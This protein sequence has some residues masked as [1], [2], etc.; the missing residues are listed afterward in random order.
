MFYV[1]NVS[2]VVVITNMNRCKVLIKMP[3][4]N[5]RLSYDDYF[6]TILK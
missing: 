1:S 2:N 6:V 3:S 4:A 5:F